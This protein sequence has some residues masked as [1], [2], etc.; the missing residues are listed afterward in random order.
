MTE[1][2]LNLLKA[3]DYESN[4]FT[5][6]VHC[7]AYINGKTYIG[8]SGQYLVSREAA[9]ELLL[10]CKG[11]L[12]HIDEAFIKQYNEELHQHRVDEMREREKE[13]VKARRKQIKLTYIYVMLNSRNGLYKIGRSNN[14]IKRENTLQSEEPEISMLFQV[15]GTHEVET[16]LHQQ[17]SSKRIR[18][19]WFR[20][21]QSD[22][23]AIKAEYDNTPF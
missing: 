6:N 19:E 9:Y 5:T 12:Q 14:P 20:L 11:Y 22:I 4:P 3:F 17:Y 8:N 15:P 13:Y 21:E 2:N 23:D 7:A 1:Q 10:K 18:G 16:R